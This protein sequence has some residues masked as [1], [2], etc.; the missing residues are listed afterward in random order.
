MASLERR[1]EVLERT[2]IKGSKPF[3]MITVDHTNYL[4]KEKEI[5]QAEA[6]GYQVIAIYSVAA[7][8]SKPHPDHIKYHKWLDRNKAKDDP[9]R[10]VK[11]E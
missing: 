7:L 11:D 10:L 3:Q 9:M 6:D 2:D 5:E 4:E 8:D 1:I